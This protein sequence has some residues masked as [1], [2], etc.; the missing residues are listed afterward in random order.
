MLEMPK[1]GIV[2]VYDKYSHILNEK[3]IEFVGVFS[4]RDEADKVFQKFRENL[5]KKDTL[6]LK[7]VGL[8]HLNQEMV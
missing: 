1:N 3:R 7:S 8:L 4:D 2:I 5:D 6:T